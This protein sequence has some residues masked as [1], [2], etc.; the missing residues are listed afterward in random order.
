MPVAKQT[1]FVRLEGELATPGVYQVL[2]GETLRQLVTR[3]GGVSRNAYVYGSEFTRES[4][5]A[6]QQ[7]RL[8]EA[9]DRFAQE[10]ERTAALQG[11]R[12]LDP[13]DAGRAQ[14]QADSNRRLLDRMR[15]VEANGRVV[16]DLNPGAQNAAG[17]SHL[18]S[19]WPL[20]FGR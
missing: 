13:A 8:E 10:I 9:L 5:R 3:V 12:A 17:A 18:S 1:K 7:K 15:T 2:P 11:Q 14:V 19:T 6:E 20:R 16:L 4:V